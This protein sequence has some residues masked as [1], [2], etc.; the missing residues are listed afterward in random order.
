M[1]AVRVSSSQNVTTDLLPTSLTPCLTKRSPILLL[2]EG[3]KDKN[4]MG[5]A[6]NT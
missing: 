1:G 3:E 6:L 5:A 2:K 4:F